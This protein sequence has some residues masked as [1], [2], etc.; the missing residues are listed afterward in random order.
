MKTGVESSPETSCRPICNIRHTMDN[1]EHYTD[2]MNQLLPQ[3][4][5]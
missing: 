3:N 4:T 2:I 5:G 1:V